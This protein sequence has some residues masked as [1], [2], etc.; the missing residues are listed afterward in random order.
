MLFT[1]HQLINSA[2]S[3]DLFILPI[4]EYGCAGALPCELTEAP[5]KFGISEC[6]S[7]GGIV[8]FALRFFFSFSV[9]RISYITTRVLPALKCG[10]DLFAVEMSVQFS[11]HPYYWS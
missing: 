2:L 3:F 11:Q 5:S 1:A 10:V 6:L 9:A 4:G 7:F 8:W